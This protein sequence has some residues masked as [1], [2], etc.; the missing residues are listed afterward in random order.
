PTST[1]MPTSATS[2]PVVVVPTFAPKMTQTACESVS[3]PALTNPTEATVTALDD[4][5]SAV[6]STPANSPRR[7]V[8]VHDFRIER[9]AF[10]A[11]SFSPSVIICMPSRKR[12]MPPSSE[13]IVEKF[14]VEGSRKPL[15]RSY[16][17]RKRVPG[18]RR[19]RRRASRLLSRPQ[20]RAILHGYGGASRRQLDDVS[21]N[22]M[23][24]SS[25][26][27]SSRSGQMRRRRCRTARGSIG[28]PV[29]APR[30]AKEKG[31]P[32][33]PPPCSSGRPFRARS[34]LL[35]AGRRDRCRIPVLVGF[36]VD[37]TPRVE[38][39]RR[40]GLARIAR[41][42]ILTRDKDDDD[43]VLGHDLGDR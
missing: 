37:E 29:R 7:L 27:A 33:S 24:Q 1:L 38:P 34:G 41:I 36:A 43:V 32:E 10:P 13:A 42:R 35:L 22:A 4:W 23:E 40:V 9:S 17:P 21:A 5:T 20:P 30:R 16:R 11:A 12:P 19:E 6:I 31:R 26:S 3:S 14:T 39:R 18:P 28:G 15:H 25:A 2:Q 8:P